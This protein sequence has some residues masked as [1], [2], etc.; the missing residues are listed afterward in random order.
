MLLSNLFSKRLNDFVNSFNNK[1]IIYC[2]KIN[3]NIN[4]WLVDTGRNSFASYFEKEKKATKKKKIADNFK[5]EGVEG[6]NRDIS[7]VSIF[8]QQIIQYNQ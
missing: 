3:N 8:Y 6:A 4:L 5:I 1:N 7:K 2:C